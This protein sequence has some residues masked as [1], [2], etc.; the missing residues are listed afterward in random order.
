[1]VIRVALLIAVAGCAIDN[2]PAAIPALDRA[3]FRCTVQPVLAARCAF[4]A[5]HGTRERPLALYAPGRERF[6]VGW[7]RPTAP[8]TTA[9]LDANFALASGFTTTT[10]T[11]EPWLLAKPLAVGEGGYYHRGADLYAAG[12]VFATRDDIG[13]RAIAAWIAGTTAAQDCTPITE[14]GP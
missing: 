1:M 10:A 5:C 6:Q 14:V 3:A 8:I 4:A 9:E 11:G 7:D 2:P 13:Y 12:D